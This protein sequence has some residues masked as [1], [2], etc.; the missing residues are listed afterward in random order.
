MP[1]QVH[2]NS[3]GAEWGYL[4]LLRAVEPF[5]T[6]KRTSSTGFVLLTATNRTGAS[7]VVTAAARAATAPRTWRLGSQ[8]LCSPR[9]NLQSEMIHPTRAHVRVR[10][11]TMGPERSTLHS[12]SHPP[13]LSLALSEA[14]EKHARSGLLLHLCQ[15][16]WDSH[17]G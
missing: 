7:G 3:M 13:C 14:R 16:L 1:Q 17:C 15:L 2:N 5:K 11:G 6:I 10:R 8:S 12:H 4:H 9:F